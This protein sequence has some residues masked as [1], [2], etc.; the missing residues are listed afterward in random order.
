M[1][2]MSTTGRPALLDQLAERVCAFGFADVTPTA[3]A[4]AKA[5]IVDTVG[6]TLA[7]LSAPCTQLLLD[8]PGVATAPGDCLVFGTDRRT[9]ALEAALVNGTAS[10]ALDYDD[11]CDAFGGHQSVPLLPAL[12]ALAE[13]RHVSGAAV[14]AA[15]VVGVEAEIRLARAVH[16]AHYDK[17]WH[18]TSTLGVFGCAAACAHLLG[19][20]AA[21]TATALA[22]AA[23]FASGL[24]A[25]FGTM[26]KPLHVGHCNRDGLLAVL[27]AERGFTANPGAMEHHQGFFDV[28][29]GPGQYDAERLLAGWGDSL[30][31]EEPTIGLKQ[32]PC[33]GSTHQAIMMMLKLRQEE[34]ITAADVDGIEVL[35]HGRRFRHT[36]TPLPE[37]PLQAKFS[38]QY[39][40]VRALLSGA[41]RLADFEGDAFRQPEVRRLLER[42]TAR[43]HPEW[44]DDGPNKWGAVV[45]VALKDG[46]RLERRV[47][48]MVG[49]SGDNAMTVEELRGKF[50]D[51]A[52]RVLPEAQIGPLFDALLGLDG[53]ADVAEVTRLAARG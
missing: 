9:S 33:C 31:L 24:K 39:A 37:G 17:G 19:L 34:G 29:N 8:T 2:E 4:V 15:Y 13:E 25:N 44:G 30:E 53:V 12:L 20:D 26:T 3:L 36:N 10:H 40:V 43:V 52:A 42:T 22:I 14:L 16:P 50:D 28:F 18:P 51:C 5:G 45:A 49:R 6:V 41:V 1:N 7:G 48:H 38:V 32:F 11:F 21:R 47:D 27:L 23:S 35:V 46:R